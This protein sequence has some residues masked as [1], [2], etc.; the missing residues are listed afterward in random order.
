MPPDEHRCA[1]KFRSL[2]VSSESK[3]CRTRRKGDGWFDSVDAPGEVRS[4]MEGLV[5]IA[6]IP[7]VPLHDLFVYRV[8]EALAARVHPGMRVRIPLG[9]QTRTGVIAG[10][11]AAPPKEPVR[12]VLELLDAEE[13][14]LP[15]DLLELCR[16]TARYYLSSLADV[17]ATIVPSV[18]PAGP[19]PEALRLVR[20]L[21]DDEL[22]ALT[23]RAPA[24]AR[25]YTSLAGA[26]GGILPRD[27]AKAIGL[28][29][30]AVRSLCRA[31]VVQIVA[32]E[33]SGAEPSAHPRPH[34][35]LTPGQ[36]AATRALEEAVVEG[37]HKTFLLHGI[38]GSGKT[39]VFLAAAERTR[40]EGRS[41][42]ILVP[43][44]ALTHQLVERVRAYFGNTVALLHSGLA[45]G[46]RWREWRRVRSGLSTVV[47]GARSAVFAPLP[48]LGLIVVDEIGRASCRG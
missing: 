30:A 31:G 1:G 4:V 48:N 36:H 15:T 18:V 23:R 43:E 24:Q 5:E 7:P 10:F 46:A 6:L 2:E 37:S 25:V 22:K 19:K 39:E 9:R 16:W 40:A 29:P 27:A 20:V 14:F 26:G 41:V 42:L 21:D 12:P 47:V 34:L 13:P 32:A 17:L 28:R 38:T 11:A 33:S 45:P 8:P 35:D 44:I 3:T